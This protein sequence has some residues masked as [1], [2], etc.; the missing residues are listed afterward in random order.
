MTLK[1]HVAADQLTQWWDGYVCGKSTK[2]SRIIQIARYYLAMSFLKSEGFLVQDVL[3]SDV[4]TWELPTAAPSRWRDLDQF[5]YVERDEMSISDKQLKIYIEA[6]IDGWTRKN[7]KKCLLEIDGVLEL[8]ADGVLELFADGVVDCAEWT[9]EG[10]LEF[11][12]TPLSAEKFGLRESDVYQSPIGR[13]LSRPIHLNGPTVVSDLSKPG[14]MVNRYQIPPPFAWLI[15]IKRRT[16]RGQLFILGPASIFPHGA[17]SGSVVPITARSP[18]F[19]VRPHGQS[20]TPSQSTMT[21]D[22]SLESLGRDTF[23]VDILQCADPSALLLEARVRERRFDQ[24]A[25][26]VHALAPTDY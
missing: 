22:K 9:S 24:D 8:F 25:D 2:A 23:G 19:P 17:M 11:K 7:F 12:V 1:V 10:L 21:S 20:C 4:A 16:W 6:M 13:R 26:R 18:S 5:R 14:Y 3:G 15:D